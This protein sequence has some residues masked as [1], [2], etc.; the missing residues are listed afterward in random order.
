[1]C[2]IENEITDKNRSSLDDNEQTPLYL[3]TTKWHAAQRKQIKK[4]TSK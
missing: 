4:I 2:D 3:T 1:M